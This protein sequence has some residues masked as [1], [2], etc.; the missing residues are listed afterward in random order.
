MKK[1]DVIDAMALIDDELTEESFSVTVSEKTR[2]RRLGSK[3]A[4]VAAIA[5][6]ALVIGYLSASLLGIIPSVIPGIGRYSGVSSGET[7]G[8]PATD[9]PAETYDPDDVPLPGFPSTAYRTV[10][11]VSDDKKIDYNGDGVPDAIE[12]VDKTFSLDIG[13]RRLYY[14][15]FSDGKTGDRICFAGLMGR[16]DSV[17][18]N[19]GNTDGDE[20]YS[21]I[22]LHA[23]RADSQTEFGVPLGKIMP[24]ESVPRIVNY[25]GEGTESFY[26]WFG[27]TPDGR[28]DGT[29]GTFLVPSAVGEEEI[30]RTGIRTENFMVR[31]AEGPHTENDGGADRLWVAGWKTGQKALEL[32]SILS[33]DLSE[34]QASSIEK[35]DRSG[36]YLNL[37]FAAPA[38][39]GEYYC[40]GNFYLLLYDGKRCLV[41]YRDNPSGLSE[42]K[43]I[44]GSD[45]YAKARIILR[46]SFGTSTENLL[47]AID[48]NTRERVLSDSDFM[49]IAVD[50][51]VRDFYSRLESSGFDYITYEN[52]R[53][54]LDSPDIL[55]F[56]EMTAE[57]KERSPGYDEK[58]ILSRI[59]VFR[60]GI[61]TYRYFV[62][63]DD[64]I[65]MM[66]GW[67]L[68]T[69]WLYDYD[70]DGTDDIV[71]TFNNGSGLVRPAQ[72]AIDLRDMTLRRLT[73]VTYPPEYTDSWKTDYDLGFVEGQ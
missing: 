27:T 20:Q 45:I 56:V 54:T 21:V 19:I 53:E 36:T 14:L 42:Q 68:L 31:L 7:G 41:T 28:N 3:A 13:G 9:A 60:Y 8:N 57:L 73:L 72:V 35:M 58:G 71:F 25:S 24:G 52:V 39:N 4:P 69:V 15:Y 18:I 63:L 59:R 38:E 30:E 48:K 40:F 51:G 12:M 29:K 50:K 26:G 61:G 1:S 34:R 37:F 66:S 17:F 62:T 64:R 22:Y 47:G 10:K 49:K 70:S 44:T 11:I 46:E 67:S 23:F 43:Y 6:A 65:Y 32:Y 5:A 2:V 55:N 33:A 16:N